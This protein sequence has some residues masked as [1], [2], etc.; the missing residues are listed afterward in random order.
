MMTE[1]NTLFTIPGFQVNYLRENDAR[2]LQRLLE[3]CTD[4]CMLVDGHP[5]G[6]NSAQALIANR[7]EDRSINDKAVFGLYNHERNLVGVLDVL[8]NY[9]FQ[10]DWWIGLMLIDPDYRNQGL[11]RQIVQSFMDWVRLQRVKRIY[12]GVVECNDK[13]FKFWQSVGFTVVERQPPRKFGNLTH[14]VIKMVHVFSREDNDR[15]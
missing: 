15:N 3:N 9:P 8:K 10:N 12:L 1:G 13:A 5:P 7:P 2:S 6:E 4:Y 14:I 11:G